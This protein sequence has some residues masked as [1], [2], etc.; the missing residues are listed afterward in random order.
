VVYSCQRSGYFRLNE[1]KGIRIMAIENQKVRESKT[2]CPKGVFTEDEF[3]K[4]VKAV[5]RERKR[6]K[7][8]NFMV[9]D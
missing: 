6:W 1:L 7:G 8:N 2:I 9:G 5:D 4:M 3:L